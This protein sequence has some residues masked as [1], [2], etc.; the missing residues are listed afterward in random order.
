MELFDYQVT[1]AQ[2]LASRKYG[3]LADQM[4]LGKTVQAV[5]AAGDICCADRVTVV[6]P[7]SVL[8]NWEKRFSLDSGMPAKALFTGKD[9][10]LREGVNVL[11]YDMLRANPNVI[12]APQDVVIFDEGHYLK[13]PTALRSKAALGKNGLI[14]KSARAWFLSGTPMPNYPHELWLV[15]YV[16]GVIK[17]DYDAFK[18][19]Y[20]VV[21]QSLYGPQVRGARNLKELKQRIAPF[22]LRRRVADVLK[23][24]PKLLISTCYVAPGEVDA[25]LWF[26]EYELGVGRSTA[27]RVAEEMKLLE[28]ATRGKSGEELYSLLD[29]MARST[30]TLH[31]YQGL[32][33]VSATADKARDIL[34]GT[35]EQ[36]AI[37]C[38][39]RSVLSAL[40]AELEEFRPV[41]VTGG[42]SRK[43]QKI[44]KF[45]RPGNK[46]RV[47]L[48]QIDAIGTGTDG[49]Q[50]S[51]CRALIVESGRTPGVN[52]QVIGRLHRYG[53]KRPV[54]VEFVVLSDNPV[55]QRLIESMRQ[56]TEAITMLF[57]E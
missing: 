22:F 20:C 12:T 51:C 19:R 32:A 5:V 43:E 37:F 10:P 49:L 18:A 25:S 36:L 23:S 30:P 8:A 47:F 7:A 55:E 35:G 1:G 2:W 16:C 44:E 34:K 6:S 41:I 57:D 39:H 52:A 21:T 17:E 3:Y 24:L 45:N 31:R 11:S 9:T 4:G 56:R 29:T 42:T 13:E 28:E 53:Q 26:P 54:L 33:K 38:R 40:H 46:C 48:G 15:L 27:Q 50:E 14:S